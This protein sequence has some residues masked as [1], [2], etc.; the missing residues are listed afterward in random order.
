MPTNRLSE[1]S[2]DLQHKQWR[3]PETFK[4]TILMTQARK[5]EGLRSNY[6]GGSSCCVLQ[7]RLLGQE[8]GDCATQGIAIQIQYSGTQQHK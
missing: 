5:L 4:L 2:S 7:A 1:R 6:H 8:A 3:R